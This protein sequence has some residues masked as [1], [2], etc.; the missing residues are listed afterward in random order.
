M[1]IYDYKLELKAHWIISTG[2]QHSC[3]RRAGSL[4]GLSHLPAR[5]GPVG[6]MEKVQVNDTNVLYGFMALLNAVACSSGDFRHFLMMCS[7]KAEPLMKCQSFWLFFSPFSCSFSSVHTWTGFM[8]T[9]Y[10]Y[11]HFICGVALWSCACISTVLHTV[12]DE[13]PIANPLLR[14]SAPALCF[15]PPL[16]QQQEK[17]KKR[18]QRKDESNDTWFE[19]VLNCPVLTGAALKPRLFLRSHMSGFTRLRHFV[20]Q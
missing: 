15:F 13:S 7:F 19:D 5:H 3:W 14:T 4:D 17:E 18:S 2:S 8:Y 10:F 1:L 6:I 12:G 20:S 11:K 9:I 16:I